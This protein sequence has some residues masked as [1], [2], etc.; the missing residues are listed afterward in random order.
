MKLW[1]LEPR[2]SILDLNPKE[3]PWYH[4]YDLHWGYVIRAETEEKARHIAAE[5]GTDERRG[6]LSSEYSTC[7]ELFADGEEGVILD[8]YRAG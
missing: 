3:N 5:R 4:V 2:E 6:W 7:V 8:D 1:L